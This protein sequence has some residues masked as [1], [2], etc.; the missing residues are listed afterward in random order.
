MVLELQFKNHID[1]IMKDCQVILRGYLRCTTCGKIIKR[2]S[3]YNKFNNPNITN[4]EL[5]I[6]YQLN[7]CCLKHICRSDEII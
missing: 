2:A 1:K 3:I 7:M 4:K 5:S 6:N